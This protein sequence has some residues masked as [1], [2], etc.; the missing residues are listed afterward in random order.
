MAT[1]EQSRQAESKRLV[2][3]S[4]QE[5]ILMYNRQMNWDQGNLEQ[6]AHIQALREEI[7]LRAINTGVLKDLQNSF[8]KSY[9]LV[10]KKLTLR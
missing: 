8:G 6:K 1:F 4:D 3:L 9:K 2:H 7:S 5:L 10:G